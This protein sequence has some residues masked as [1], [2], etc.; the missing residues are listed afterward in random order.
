MMQWITI[1]KRRHHLAMGMTLAALVLIS[2]WP[3]AGY[4]F[5]ALDDHLYLVDNPPIQAGMTSKSLWWA[6]TTFHT[7]NWHPA[8]WISYMIDF[9]LFGLNPGGYHFVN[10]MLHLINTILLFCLFSQ[11]TGE[12]WKGGFIAA[13]FAVHPLN[14]ESVV[15]IAERK[16]LLSTL[17][18]ILTLMAYVRYTKNPDWKR[19]GLILV[20]FISG[21][22]SKPILVALPFVLLLI[23][24]WPLKRFPANSGLLSENIGTRISHRGNPRSLLIE[25]IPLFVLSF[26]SCV[27]TFLAARSGGAVKS[28][29][30]FPLAA[31]IENAIVAYS[32]YIHKMVWPVDLAIF[33][34]FPAEIPIWH[35]GLS[36]VFLASVS[37]LVCTKGR[38]CRYLVTGW[39]W[40]LAFLLPVIGIVQVGFQSMANRYAYL[41]LIGI[42][43]MMAWGVPDLVNRYPIRKRLPTLAAAAVLALMICTMANLPNWKNSELVFSHALNVTRENPI[44]EMGMGNVFLKRGDMLRAIPHY[45]ESLRIRSDYAEAHN[46]LAIAFMRMGKLD[47]AVEQFKEALKDNPDYAEAHNNL[48]AVFAGQRLWSEAERSFRSA[49]RLRPDYSGAKSN[50]ERLLSEQKRFECA[51]GSEC[52]GKSH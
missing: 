8:T 9:R 49:L 4:D 39:L 51:S 7:T 5:I 25:K 48:G 1:Q 37:V 6:I 50:L 13:L 10:L 14:L 3:V 43:I 46:N 30:A 19:Y 42:W 36:V 27:V 38:S 18:G 47:D 21:L 40:Y 29:A 15:W 45:Q 41:P 12:I 22:M 26:L 2:Y 24:Y 44:A 17:W 28:L 32:N 23:D 52:R 35:L 34:P 31:R 33:Y 20:C 11:M 16:N